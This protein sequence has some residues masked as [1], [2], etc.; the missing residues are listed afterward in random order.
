MWREEK[1][2]GTPCITQDGEDRECGPD[3]YVRGIRNQC[4]VGYKYFCF[5]DCK[6]IRL[7]VRGDADGILHIR[8]E[9]EGADVAVIEMKPGGKNDTEWCDVSAEFPVRGKNADCIWNLKETEAL[10]CWR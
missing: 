4:I 3:Q 2:A 5:A 9:E 6:R 10:T 7:A 8:M 1:L